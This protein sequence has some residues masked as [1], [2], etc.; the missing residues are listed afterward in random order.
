M[1]YVDTAMKEGIVTLTLQRGKVNALNYEV[2]RELT[3][4]FRATED[5]SQAKVVILTGSGS[6]FSFGFD[7]P[8]FLSCSKESFTRFLQEFTSFYTYLY[9]YPKPVIAALNGHTIAGGCMI[10]TACDYRTM[11]A[12]KAKISLNEITFGSS[13]F[14]GSVEMLRHCVGD[15]N[16]R[17]ILYTGRMFTGEEAAEIGLV[18]EVV[19]E[20]AFVYHVFAQAVDLAHRSGPA[21]TSMKRLLRSPIAE[22]MKNAEPDSIHEFTEIWY[23][24]ETRKQLQQITIRE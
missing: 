11:V 2:V 7:I 23:S 10:A 4:A 6:F 18:D 8:G 5:D 14:A 24:E 3:A 20:E 13:V 16:A 22:R 12:G 1:R 19:K 21:F 17:D 9:L 15:R